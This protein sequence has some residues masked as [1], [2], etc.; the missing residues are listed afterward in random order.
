MSSVYC[1]Y[2]LTQNH[3]SIGIKKCHGE[4]CMLKFIFLIVYNKIYYT[5]CLNDF[6]IFSWMYPCT[7]DM[8]QSFDFILSSKLP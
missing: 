7:G 2:V 3:I 4:R 8:L 1:H 6:N 5:F